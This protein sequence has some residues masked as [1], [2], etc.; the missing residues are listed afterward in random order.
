MFDC[1]DVI[2]SIEN[3]PTADVVEVVRCRDCKHWSP[4]D[5]GLSWN[6]K[7]RT[8]GMCDMLY[9]LHYAERHLTDEDHFCSYGKRKEKK[10]EDLQ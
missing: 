1:D 8:D 5:N 9:H 6:N 7:G 3:T 4:M 2:N 10:D